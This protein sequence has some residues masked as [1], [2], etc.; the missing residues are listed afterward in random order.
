MKKSKLKISHFLNSAKSINRVIKLKISAG[1][2]NEKDNTLMNPFFNS[3]TMKEK[4][5]NYKP[6]ILSTGLSLPVKFWDNEEKICLAPYQD[7]NG[8]IENL[9]KSVKMIYD[10]ICEVKKPDEITKEFF[11]NKIDEIIFKK[12]TS[13]TDAKKIEKKEVFR[14]VEKLSKKKEIVI[15]TEHNNIFTKWIEWKIEQIKLSPDTTEKE[16][17]GEGTLTNYNKFKNKWEKFELKNG[18]DG[19]LLSDLNDEIIQKFLKY[20]Q[21]EC[22]N[23]RTGK[24]YTYQYFDFFKKT[25]KLFINEARVE[26]DIIIEKVELQ[27]RYLKKRKPVNNDVYLTL[28]QQEKIKKLKYDKDDKKDL[29]S[30]KVRDLLIMLCTVGC[31]YTD[32]PRVV[33]EN[34]NGVNIFRYRRGKNGNLA[35]GKIYDNDFMKL[36]KKYNK[37]FPKMSEENFNREVK[38]IIMSAGFSQKVT[39]YEYNIREKKEL[40]RT[41]LFHQ[42]FKSRCCR[43]SMATT[44]L[45]E[46]KLRPFE[47][48]LMGGW[49]TEN[50]MMGYLC[51][52]KDEAAMLQ[53]DQ[54]KFEIESL[55]GSTPLKKVG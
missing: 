51:I 41:F 6:I 22:H 10:S 49:S 5:T 40:P 18:Y 28:E 12:K 33:I 44:G 26:D 24:P 21:M 43:K 8:K 36:W 47:V 54:L 2:K 27:K 17:R 31:N 48:R 38:K 20:V 46:R 39:V 16:N 13:L 30:E 1:F 42:G 3:A 55:T 25:I 11:Q 14:N 32:I 9:K 50:S 34:K 15:S 35:Y 37:S 19:I 52:T 45:Y 53:E 29:A 23:P 7:Y 4:E